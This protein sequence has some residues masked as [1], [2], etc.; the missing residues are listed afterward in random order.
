M[1]RTSTG[2]EQSACEPSNS[3]G[4]AF[5]GSRALPRTLAVVRTDA[6]ALRPALDFLSATL[7]LPDAGPEAL[8]VRVE[9]DQQLGPLAEDIAAKLA[10]VSAAAPR[11]GPGRTG[12]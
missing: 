8:L 2:E 3:F 1:S 9:D 10:R 7:G 5:P 4:G 6:E 12:P 11:D